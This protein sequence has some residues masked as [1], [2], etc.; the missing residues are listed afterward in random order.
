MADLHLF[1][2][3]YFSINRLF[4]KNLGFFICFF[5][6]LSSSYATCGLYHLSTTYW[7]SLSCCDAFLS[8]SDS[9]VKVAS[10]K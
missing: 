9:N 1:L 8:V 3:F 10:I 7:I 5:V 2:S 4:H 6:F